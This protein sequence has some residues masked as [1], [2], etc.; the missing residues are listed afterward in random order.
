MK[1]LILSTDSYKQSHYLQYPNGMTYMH[2]YI[3]SRGGSYGVTKFFGLQYYL[4]EYLSK[5][6]TK[7]MVQ[8]AKGICKLHGVPFNE[9]GW[10]YIAKLG[11]LPI[12]IR[13][14]EEG[15]VVPNHNVLIT[16]ESTDEKVAWITGFV[17]TLIMKVWYPI[18]VTTFS[19]KIKKI[20]KEFLDKTS[21]NPES[22]LLTRFHD[23]GYRGVSSEES[24]GIGGMAHLVNFRGTDTLNAV[25]YAKKYYNCK[26]AGFSIPA[27][28]HSTMTSWKKENEEKAFENMIDKF[29]GPVSIVSD[30]YNFFNAVDYI[31]GEDLKEK[32]KNHKNG[33]VIIRPDS[34]DA[35]TN[36]LFA[37]ESLERNFGS[38]TNSK[39]FKVL[40]D[41]RIIQGDG[42]NEDTI[43]DLCK[44]IMENG[45]SIENV[46][47]GCGGAL[48]QGNSHSSINRDTHRFAMKCSAAIIN[49]E[50]IDI[51][52]NPITDRGKVSKKGIL[53]LI[54]ENGE[55][56]T[57]NI[58]KDK[59]HK[60]SVMKTVFENGK[61]LKEYTFDEV[62][63]NENKYKLK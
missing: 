35:I 1:N 16:V 27:S 60:N 32:I 36:V 40:N 56:K 25:L 44:I 19:Y 15:V 31:V 59:P 41:V 47:F 3:E 63:N 21:D 51:Y 20:I 2:D 48:L 23:F 24:A 55:F 57:I 29:Q 30:S 5:P 12:K 38:V 9:E 61:I 58:E 4:K 52:K 49:G 37:L 26:M 13:A 34:G 33:P 53:D 42:I 22:E 10:N 50:L 43:W 11:Y 6:I 62:R 39:G 54:Y 17:E 8:E 28:E 7:E 18:T 14:V 46:A 45:Y